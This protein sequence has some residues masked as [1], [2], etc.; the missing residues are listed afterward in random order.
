MTYVVRHKMR[1]RTN[2]YDADYIRPGNYLGNRAE[3][4]MSTTARPHTLSDAVPCEKCGAVVRLSE[5]TAHRRECFE[6]KE[7]AT[8]H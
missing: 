1:V 4:G 7:N 6:E 8:Y 2:D 3:P 5:M